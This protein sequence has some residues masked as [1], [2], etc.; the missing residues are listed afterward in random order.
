MTGGDGDDTLVWNNGDGS[1][2]MDGDDGLDRIEVNGATEAGD[3]FTIAPNGGRAK[4]DRTNLVPFTLDIG[5]TEALD[6]RGGGGN[7]TFTARP[8]TGG[9][10]AVTAD[11]GSGNDV[12]DRRRGAPTRSPAARATTPLTGG[13]G[14]DPLDGQDGNDTLVPATAR[15]DLGRGGAR[16]RQRRRPT[17]SASTCST[18]I[19]SLDASPAAPAGRRAARPATPRRPR[20]ASP[21]TPGAVRIRARPRD[22]PA[23]LSVPGRRGRRLLRHRGA[24]QRQGRPDRRRSASTVRA[25]QQPLHAAP[26]PAPRRSPCA[27][28]RAC[29]AWRATAARS[30]P[31]R[32]P[33]PATAPATSWSPRSRSA[34][35]SPAARRDARGIGPSGPSGWAGLRPLSRLLL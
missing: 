16:H 29:A 14:P 2:T 19:E 8:G 32:R 17:Q 30:P 28:P 21:A 1:D 22:H 26:R 31:A 20:S 12:A 6:A 24:V 9:L 34:C 35:G 3:A 5:T 27:C 33:S 13:A 15:S 23:A 7:D 10:L 11:G 25:R 4:F 18:A